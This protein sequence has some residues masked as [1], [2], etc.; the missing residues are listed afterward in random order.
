MASSIKPTAATTMDNMRIKNI[1]RPAPRDSMVSAFSCRSLHQ[2][3]YST[4]SAVSS[5]SNRSSIQSGDQF[6]ARKLIEA[7]TADKDGV[8]E[9]KHIAKIILVQIIP[10]V[11]LVI[12]S[13]YNMTETNKQLTMAKSTQN[14]VK[15]NELI[16]K[17]V[18]A[19][20]IERGVSATF[21]CSFRK[22]RDVLEEVYNARN[23]T[24]FA[25]EKLKVW[26][27]KSVNMID[28]DYMSSKEAF[29]VHLTL[30]RQHITT[31]GGNTS[32]I[33]TIQFYTS[34]NNRIMESG[35]EA[36]LDSNKQHLW[37][38]IVASNIILHSSDLLG[39]K[40]ALGAVHYG[41]CK[42]SQSN[43]DWFN[44]VTYQGDILAKEAFTYFPELQKQFD[45]LL[46]TDMDALKAV[47]EMSVEITQNVDVCE[48]YGMQSATKM[49]LQWFWNIT[50]IIDKMAA[51][52][53]KTFAIIKNESQQI[54]E[55]ATMN[56]II[57][58]VIE[59]V[60][61][62]GCLGCGG[63]YSRQSYTLVSTIGQYARQLT[64][65]KNELRAE[66]KLSEKLLY[67]ML[68]KSV[69][70]QLKQGQSVLTESDG[71]V[72]IYFSDIKGFTSMAK[73]ATALQV[74]N[75]LNA[76]YR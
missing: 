51:I 66:K 27:G 45:V 75:L 36:S 17:L 61:V 39:I 6:Q 56:L 24:N 34:I 16:G 35:I 74:V 9:I 21:L 76:L 73:E 13:I 71:Q 22:D 48:K 43:L 4:R 63:Y 20:Q 64:I 32:T 68:P 47:D 70:E 55:R 49:S 10:L 41:S 5:H 15:Q 60:V 58:I 42:L 31:A 72:T 54:I 14:L 62:I 25:L 28:I 69:A 18:A 65:R 50:H 30:Q 38:K 12:F 40:R 46:A 3:R 52:R 59:I 44:R 8:S 67:Q 29:V 26:P 1:K 23:R 37:S 57:Q 7:I 2:R 53:T 11:A 19:L 33:R